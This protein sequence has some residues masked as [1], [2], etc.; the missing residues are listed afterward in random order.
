ML[1]CLSEAKSLCVSDKEQRQ[2]VPLIQFLMNSGR[3]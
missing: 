1:A 3:D 2:L